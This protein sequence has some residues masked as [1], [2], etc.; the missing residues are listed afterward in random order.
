MF[1]AVG[2]HHALASGERA[3]TLTYACPGSRKGGFGSE[4]AEL[5][6]RERLTALMPG[7]PIGSLSTIDSVTAL[8]L[9]DQGPRRLQAP[10]GV[11]CGRKGGE[12][13]AEAEEPG[14]CRRR[15]AEASVGGRP[16]TGRRDRISLGLTG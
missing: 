1:G 3:R 9:G 15:C 5:A 11:R 2:F 4:R 8:M 14:R 10:R 16:G 6:S 12:P 7:A 13:S